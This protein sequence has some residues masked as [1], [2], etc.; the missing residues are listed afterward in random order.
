M[1]ALA[2]LLLVAACDR[3]F[4]LDSTALV[5][6][7]ID[8]DGDGVPDLRD[9]CPSIP[10]A[11]QSDLDGDGV[12]D[13]CDNCPLVENHPPVGEAQAD[14]DM[15]GVGDACDPHPHLAGDCLQLLDEFDDPSAFATNWQA[16]GSTASHVTV[17]PRALTL[18]PTPSETLTLIANGT[19][20]NAN[21]ELLGSADPMAPGSLLVIMQAVGTTQGFLCAEA[22]SSTQNDIILSVNG[23]LSSSFSGPT[24]GSPIAGAL[25]M[26]LEV[27]SSGTSSDLACLFDHGF[28][29]G[30]LDFSVP[31]V[32]SGGG[33]G[34]ATTGI[35][36]IIEAFAAY[37]FHS[38]EPCPPTMYR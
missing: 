25:F 29:V 26:R 8:S 23:S 3:A 31:T 14:S 1:R 19:D 27:D 10:N 21:V 37:S 18:M 17:A 16:I 34:F 9:N 33:P 20:A 13:V 11:D 6:A 5:D 4:G 35:P 15:D 2:A 30:T 12:G 28:A 7:G 32:L 36:M 24:F 22:R 38:G